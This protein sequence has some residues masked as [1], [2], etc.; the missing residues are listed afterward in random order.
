MFSIFK[1]QMYVEYSKWMFS[2]TGH[3]YFEKDNTSIITY[4]NCYTISA[5]LKVAL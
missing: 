5:P 3:H 1:I 2:N 4:L